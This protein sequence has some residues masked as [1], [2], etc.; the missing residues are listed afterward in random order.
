[1]RD[2]GLVKDLRALR[3]PADP[4]HGGGPTFYRELDGGKKQWINPA[5][6]GRRA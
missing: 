2:V 3:Q 4:G 6:V 5:D 1:M